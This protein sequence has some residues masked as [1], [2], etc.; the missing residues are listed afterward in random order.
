[1]FLTE[2]KTKSTRVEELDALRGIAIIMVVLFHYFY[3]YGQLYSSD[4]M[5]DVAKYGHLGVEL[6]FIISGFVIFYSLIHADSLKRFWVG[7]AARIIPAYWFSVVVIFTLTH[8]F[9]LPGR[10]AG[11]GDMLVNLTLLQEYAGFKHVDGVYW[12]LTIEITF[13]FWVSIF[14]LR[15]PSAAKVMFII[16]PIFLICF[17]VIDPDMNSRFQKIFLVKYGALL[18]AGICYS[19]IHREKFITVSIF[20]LIMCMVVNSLSYNGVELAVVY[21][22]HCIM[23]AVALKKAQYLLIKPLMYF[24]G[25]SYSLYLIHQNIGYMILNGMEQA[26]LPHWVVVAVIFP[27]M[28]IVADLM[29]RFIERPCRKWM[30]GVL[31]KKS[32]ADL[33]VSLVKK[34]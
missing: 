12:S 7:R 26:G 30:Y 29:V 17:Y 4:D 20:V 27:C 3:R 10:E 23:L 1:M 11:V 6:F 5:V 14:L 9:G 25:I 2:Q 31:L 15:F 8:I 16:Y 13:Y 28:V 19:N 34:V 22:F 21:T 33:S 24:G 32:R 18:F